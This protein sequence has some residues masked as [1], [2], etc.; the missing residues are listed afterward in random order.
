M[1]FFNADLK[2]KL[3]AVLVLVGLIPAIF[4]GFIG[5]DTAKAQL[6]GEISTKLLILSATK[7]TQVELYLSS[8][9]V[10]AVDFSSDGF[11]RDSLEKIAKGEN[12]EETR[13]AFNRHL[14]VNKKSL[15]PTM[16]GILILDKTGTVA[17]STDSRE[18]G[19]NEAGEEYF[20]KGMRGVSA[21]SKIIHPAFETRRPITVSAPLTSKDTGELLGV[22]ANVHDAEELNEIISIRLGEENL[23][24]LKPAAEIYLIDDEM[25]ILFHPHTK[26]EVPNPDE[27]HGNYSDTPLVRKCIAS[28]QGGRAEYENPKKSGVI[29]TSRCL[30]D[31]KWTLLVEIDAQQARRPIADFYLKLGTITLAFAAITAIIAFLLASSIAG[32]IKK[33][34]QKIND[35]SLGKLDVEIGPGLKESGDEI[36]E[37]ARAFDRTIVSLKLSLREH[38]PQ[39]KKELE[40]QRESETGLLQT[41]TNLDEA[42]RMLAQ[43]LKQNMQQK[44]ELLRALQDKIA[45]E[46]QLKAE[47][48]LAEQYFTLAGVM[49]V[50][51]DRDGIVL[52]VNRKACDVLGYS[53]GELLG[54]KWFKFLSKKFQKHCEGSLKTMLST[55]KEMPCLCEV[56]TKNGEIKPTEWHDV[57]LID[58]KG[59]AIGALYAGREAGEKI[60]DPQAHYGHEIRRKTRKQM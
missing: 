25:K 50:V 5:Y 4:T 41:I 40:K 60:E 49:L 56:Q 10:R 43:A 32:P 53:Q 59:N 12:T 9:Q 20:Q 29:G 36:G 15:D 45:V 35:I 22:I 31:R 46:G 33:L 19:R 38:A 44:R 7:E 16:K 52:R 34:T 48:Q 27:F 6:E 21:S 2:T 13:A 55:K 37:L 1:D 42:Q 51:L 8:L 24:A 30:A 54:K 23:S 17:A 39:L 18:I 14:S 57:P 26:K 47:K 58:E 11:I 28:G 3:V